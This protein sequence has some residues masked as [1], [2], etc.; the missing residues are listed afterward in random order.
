MFSKDISFA[1][2]F[3]VEKKLFIQVKVAG[4]FFEWILIAVNWNSEAE[5]YMQME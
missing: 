2:N 3:I 4:F 5:K 1:D